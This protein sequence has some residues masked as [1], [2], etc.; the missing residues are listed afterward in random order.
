[1]ATTCIYN[2]HQLTHFSNYQHYT[3]QMSQT[4]PNL[5]TNNVSNNWRQRFFIC[6]AVCMARYGHSGVCSTDLAFCHA[7]RIHTNCRPNLLQSHDQE[8]CT[9]SSELMQVDSNVAIRFSLSLIKQEVK[10][11]WQKAPHGGPI[12][13]L[14]VTPGGRRLYHW[15]PGVGFPISVP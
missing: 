6:C 11:I 3:A 10:V 15:I 7:T 1:M 8:V 9:I 14:G 12:P 4:R 13:R 5:H 2:G